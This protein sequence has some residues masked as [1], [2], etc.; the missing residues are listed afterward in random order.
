M[1]GRK[2]PAAGADGE[3]AQRA[4]LPGEP[5]LSTH[6]AG[7]PPVWGFY[8]STVFKKLVIIIFFFL[9]KII[10][11][12]DRVFSFGEVGKKNHFFLTSKLGLVRSF[13]GFWSNMLT[14]SELLSSCWRMP[15]SPIPKFFCRYQKPDF[16]SHQRSGTNITLVAKKLHKLQIHTCLHGTV[17]CRG[18]WKAMARAYL[19]VYSRVPLSTRRS[20]L[21]GVVMLWATDFFPL[22]KKVS[23]VQILLASRLFRGSIFMGP[24]NFSLSS[25]QDCRKKTSMVYSFV[26]KGEKNKSRFT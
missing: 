10:D 23:G 26:E 16:I 15:N 12:T 18:T 5:F 13:T 14:N 2:A 25:L 21:L 8:R 7:L 3:A 9:M 22:W 20:S 19:M 17:M 11:Y 1:T 4:A 6:T 24:S